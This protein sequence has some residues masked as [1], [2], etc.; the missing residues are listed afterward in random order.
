MTVEPLD[1]FGRLRAALASAVSGGASGG[2]GCHFW[3]RPT[4]GVPADQLEVLGLVRIIRQRVPICEEH[5]CAIIATCKE[6]IVFAERGPGIG[7]R[8]FRLTPLGAQAAAEPSV[9]AAQI[10][11]QPLARRILDA[12]V[13]AHGRT[14]W[15]ELYWRLLQSELDALAETGLRPAPPLSRS[16]VRF[17][18]D[19]LVAA[20]LLSEDADTGTVWLTPV[21][22]DE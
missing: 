1:A 3:T 22:S 13:D 6:R 4:L 20:G 16:A 15:L 8:K 10:A 11:E 14:S 5:G 19:L 18:L 17:Y 7:R 2:V 21:V 12:L 9:L